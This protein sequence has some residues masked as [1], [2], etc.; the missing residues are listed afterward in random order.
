MYRYM[1]IFVIQQAIFRYA[2]TFLRICG[3]HRNKIQ[4]IC[5]IITFITRD[6]L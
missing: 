1:D 3:K 6:R 2:L 5:T 4:N